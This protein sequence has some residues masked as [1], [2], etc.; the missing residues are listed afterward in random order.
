MKAFK[1][2]K[3]KICSPFG[4]LAYEVI[5][6]GLLM[7]YGSIFVCGVTLKTLD[8]IVKYVLVDN[9]KI[10]YVNE[11]KFYMWMGI[12]IV[13]PEYLKTKVEIKSISK[14]LSNRVEKICD[15]IKNGN[16]HDKVLFVHDLICK[17]IKYRESRLDSHSVVGP[18]LYKE[19]VCDGIAKTA[20]LLLDNMGVDCCVVRGNARSNEHSSKIEGHAW[21]KVKINGKWFNMDATFDNTMGSPRDIRYDYFLVTDSSL[22]NTHAEVMD[23][24]L[25]CEDDEI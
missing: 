2:Y 13:K 25:K 21:N 10:F 23:S 5:R 17:N 8:K 9:P 1:L 7:R 22:K 16:E 20:K 12:C 11:F 24:G 18:L 3:R 6:K 19:G 15:L 14:E 4:R